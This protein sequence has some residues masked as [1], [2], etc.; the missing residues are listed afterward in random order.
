MLCGCHA[1]NKKPV[2]TLSHTKA[3]SFMAQIRKGNYS[4]EGWPQI[5]PIG[6]LD[7]DPQKQ[8][9]TIHGLKVMGN[10]YDLPVLKKLHNIEVVL[11]YS[12]GK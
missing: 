6:F 8:G 1:R 12:S 3:F 2:G 5:K 10:A 7:H 9:S 4:Y 11:H